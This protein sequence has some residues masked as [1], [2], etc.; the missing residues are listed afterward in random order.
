M[1]TTAQ[2]V[3]I[4]ILK[5]CFLIHRH[6]CHINNVFMNNSK[7][8]NGF[9]S[10][11]KTYPSFFLLIYQ[12]IKGLFLNFQIKGSQGGQINNLVQKSPVINYLSTDRLN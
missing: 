4:L 8:D 11:N 7:D 1:S 6:I 10:N 2:K 3:P 5:K 12:Y 9:F